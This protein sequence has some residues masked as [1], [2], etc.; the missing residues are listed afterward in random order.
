MTQRRRVDVNPLNSIFSILVLVLGLAAL[1][2]IAKGIFTILA[3]LAP[4]FLI[5]A[6]IIDY[7][8][9]LN[10]GKWLINLLK[11]NPLYG[12]GGILLTIIGFPV[13]SGF[14][15]A[16]AWL[17]RKINK[18]NEQYGGEVNSGEYAEYEDLT[19]EP[20]TRLELP[21][22]ETRQRRPDIKKPDNAKTDTSDYEQLFD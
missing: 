21:D 15:L 20:P 19:H 14:L 8:V 11:K 10:Y 13:V 6:A 4:V 2:F 12:I 1:Y 3:W 17:S 22:F 5:L 16:K 18:M 7:K 9:I